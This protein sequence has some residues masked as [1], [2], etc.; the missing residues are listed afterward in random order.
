MHRGGRRGRR[1]GVRFVGA[2]PG[3]DEAPLEPM[4]PERLGV[5]RA[6]ADDHPLLVGCGAEPEWAQGERV[7]RPR[8]RA[9]GAAAALDLTATA[10]RLGDRHAVPLQDLDSHHELG[11]VDE[12]R[13][14]LR[15]QESGCRLAPELLDEEREAG[16][17]SEEG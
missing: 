7:E 4:L 6:V 16:D 5:T 15:H 10:D 13:D 9:V 12:L 8:H 17:R 3:V 11:I 2:R 14:D 1:G